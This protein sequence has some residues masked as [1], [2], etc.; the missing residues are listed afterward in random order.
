MIVITFLAA[1]AVPRAGFGRADNTLRI[2]LDDVFCIG[3]E[4]RLVDCQHSPIGTHN[5]GHRED[6]GVVCQGS[7]STSGISTQSL[8]A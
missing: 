4:I 1:I 5:C 7:S 3:S 6:A 8:H 2:I